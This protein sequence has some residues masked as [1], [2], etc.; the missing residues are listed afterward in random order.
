[1]SILP[2]IDFDSAKVSKASQKLPLFKEYAWDFDKNEFILE[3]GK[4]KMITG[5]DA[6]RVW[7]W[8]ALHTQRYRYAAYTWNYGHELEELIGKGLSREAIK[9][10]VERY[11]KEA[12]LINQYI[13]SIKD[14]E[15]SIDESDIQV[16]FTVTTIYGEVKINV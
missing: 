6:V 5:K 7:V 3:A 10:E 4:Q 16:E 15:I 9:S 12:L 11:L 13:K 14:I 2:N 1:M 8:K